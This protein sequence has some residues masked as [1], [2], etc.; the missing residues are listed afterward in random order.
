VERTIAGMLAF[1]RLTVCYDRLAAVRAFLHLAC[2]LI[3]VRFRCRVDADG[4][5]DETR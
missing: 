2:V 5:Q 3:G 1:H 4:E